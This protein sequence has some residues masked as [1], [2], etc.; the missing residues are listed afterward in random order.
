MNY[1]FAAI[2]P[3][4]IH[5][6]LFGKFAIYDLEEGQQGWEEIKNIQ[7]GDQAAVINSKRNIPLLYEITKVEKTESQ[8]IVY[9]KPKERIEMNYEKFIRHNNITNNRITS[10]HQMGQ[11]FNL[12]TW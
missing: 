3:T 10:K 11:G 6:D 2:D 12:A 5:K 7:V 8:I 1:L 9:G 4:Y